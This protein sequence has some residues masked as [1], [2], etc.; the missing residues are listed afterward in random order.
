VR[1]GVRVSDVAKS[2]GLSSP[3]LYAAVRRVANDAAADVRAGD[4][5]VKLGVRVQVD[6]A[7]GWGS[8]GVFQGVATD[9]ADFPFLQELG[10]SSYPYLAGIKTPE[11]VPLDYYA[12]LV[13]DHSVPMTVSEGGWTSESLGTIKS[14]AD[15]QRRYIVRH[16][17][18]L[19]RARAI[20]VFQLTFTDLDLAGIS[21]PA[22]SILPL[23]AHL[24]L[25]DAN[26]R[27]K[28]ALSAWDEAFA[29]P[30]GD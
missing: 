19:D 23:F 2:G 27:P 3:A 28:P 7:W 29:R 15:M 21:L 4:P 12:R 1:R 13:E 22:E 5:A 8:N 17:D 20:A 30:R 26:L 14:S 10:L 9:F 25:V 6:Y 16:M 11:D 18:I 24:G